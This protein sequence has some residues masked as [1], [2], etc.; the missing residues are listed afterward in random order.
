M[1]TKRV[2]HKIVSNVDTI[3]TLKNPCLNFAVWELPEKPKTVASG[4]VGA[5]KDGS[6]PESDIPR[7]PDEDGLRNDDHKRSELTNVEEEGI[8]F[9]VCSGNLMSASSRFNTMLK[10]NGWSE[11]TRNGDD[12][13]FYLSAEDW[14]EQAFIILMNIFHLKN[15]EIPRKLSLEMLA[16]V[17]VL[18]DY[19][20][21][22]ES[23]EHFTNIW[24]AKLR[25]TVSIPTTY[26]RELVLW[27]WVAWIFKLS[28]EFER[29]THGAIIHCTDS[30]R[31]LGLPIPEW[32]TVEIN[33]RRNQS[34]GR[35][36]SQMHGKLDEY[37][38]PK[39]TC[40]QNSNRSF[41]CGCM[42]LGALTKHMDSANVFSPRPKIPFT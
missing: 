21:C 23:T 10:R 17:G 18:V 9:H 24:I 30:V 7:K 2:V 37:R 36:V 20:D 38:N 6:K 39:Y 5:G 15:R 33:E 32:V 16:K 41:E 40:A 14:D 34:I 25:A 35:I 29:A 3:I 31:D 8:H 11:S 27:M 26:C 28:D 19:Y 1:M 22:A 12:N 4:V 13:L 42:F